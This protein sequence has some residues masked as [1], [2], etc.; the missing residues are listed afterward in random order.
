MLEN[1]QKSPFDIKNKHH[2][3]IRKKRVYELYTYQPQIESFVAVVV[4]VAVVKK[5]NLLKWN[6]DTRGS[7]SWKSWFFFKLWLHIDH[8]LHTL[9]FFLVLLKAATSKIDQSRL[10]DISSISLIITNYGLSLWI[11]HSLIALCHRNW[12]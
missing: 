2:D 8:F 5:I 7:G 11:Y 12:R 1:I 9:N 6:F 4:I 10:S 3:H